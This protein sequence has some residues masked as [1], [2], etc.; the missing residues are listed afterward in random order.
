MSTERHS[1][2]AAPCVNGIPD[3]GK[4]TTKQFCQFFSISD[5]TLRD[6]IHK[7]EIPHFKPGD[8][9]ILDAQVFWERIPLHDYP[10]QE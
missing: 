7:Y 8:T 4:Y 3:T 1:T 9:I 5:K 6:W 2:D 10:K